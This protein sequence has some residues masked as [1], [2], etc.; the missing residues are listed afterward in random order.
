VK[1][2]LLAPLMLVL[3]GLANCT[4]YPAAPGY[5]AGP[6]RAF[7]V[8][9]AFGGVGLTGQDE[10]VLHD[11]AAYAAARPGTHIRIIGNADAPGA[12]E[13]NAVIS[14]R[15][16][17]VVAAEL[18]RFGVPRERMTLQAY[19]EARPVVITTPGGMQAENRRVDILIY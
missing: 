7:Q 10:A 17:E 16:A 11:A 2:W 5:Y 14:Q 8:Y 1:R 15:R 13:G 18:N 3:L 12:P 4:P 19:G 9:F 6:P